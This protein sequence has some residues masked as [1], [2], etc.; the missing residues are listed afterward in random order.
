MSS[1]RTD[2]RRQLLRLRAVNQLVAPKVQVTDEDVRA[3]YDEL[4]RRSRVGQR[5]LP[6]AHP[7]QAPRA[8]DRAAAR[9]RRRTKA[10]KAIE[11]VKAGEEFAEVAKQVSSRP[12][13]S[14]SA[15]SSAAA[16]TPSGSRSCSRWRRATCAARSPGPQGLHVFHV[17]DV[18]QSELKPYAEM[19]EQLQRELRRREM[20]KQTAALGRRAAQEGLHRH[21]AAVVAA[22]APASSGRCAAPIPDPSFQDGPDGVSRG[23]PDTMVDLG[24]PSVA[25]NRRTS[26]RHAVSLAGTIDRRMARR[27]TDARW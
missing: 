15:G 24:E 6:L 22:H 8:A 1:Y 4:Q 18:K 5:G 21:Q 27:A 11:R 13:T 3:R 12:R 20:D 10:A 7:D 14:S 23:G 2:L 16:S 19:K 26:T 25:D 9:R 17:S